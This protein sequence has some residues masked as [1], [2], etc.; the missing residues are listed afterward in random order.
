MPQSYAS[1]HIFLQKTKDLMTLHASKYMATLAVPPLFDPW[2]PVHSRFASS[3][4]YVRTSNAFVL[5][6]PIEAVPLLPLATSTVNLNIKKISSFDIIIYYI[7]HIC[8]GRNSD[9]AP[10]CAYA[11]GRS[12]C[13]FPLPLLKVYSTVI[14]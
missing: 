3:C 8:F 11:Y 1:L 14:G 10:V 13:D 7:L 5:L 12:A 6:L 4:R 2:M 9:C